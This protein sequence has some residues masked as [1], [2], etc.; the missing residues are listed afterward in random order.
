MIKTVLIGLLLVFTVQNVFAQSGKKS[1]YLNLSKTFGYLLGQDSTLARIKKEF[2]SLSL[3]AKKAELEFTL[4]FGTARKNIEKK[5][6]SLKS[7]ISNMLR[8]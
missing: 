3:Q 7:N 5:L 4:A 8:D 2:P 1:F 6:L